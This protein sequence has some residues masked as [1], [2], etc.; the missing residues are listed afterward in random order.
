MNAFHIT[1]EDLNFFMMNSNK[2]LKTRRSYTTY[3]ACLPEDWVRFR[4]HQISNI[5]MVLNY[6]DT[7]EG[8]FQN[9]NEFILQRQ[10]SQCNTEPLWIVRCNRGNEMYYDVEESYEET[11][12]LCKD[13]LKNENLTKTNVIEVKRWAFACWGEISICMETLKL[14]DGGFYVVGSMTFANGVHHKAK[15]TNN[16]T[17]PDGLKPVRVYMHARSPLAQYLHLKDPTYPKTI[18]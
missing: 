8:H 18:L 12:Q 2:F 1:L 13:N 14:V 10:I 4:D 6:F 9:Q 17:I 16:K 15:Y 11:Q 7:P 3:F 5:E